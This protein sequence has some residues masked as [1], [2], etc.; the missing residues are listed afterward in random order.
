MP[1]QS[2][3]LKASKALVAQLTNRYRCGYS[4]CDRVS[5]KAYLAKIRFGL[6]S[7]GSRPNAVDVGAHRRAPL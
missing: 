4:K 5:G 1:T 3:D 6:E 2:R 7:G